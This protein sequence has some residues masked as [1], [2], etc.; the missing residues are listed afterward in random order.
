MGSA[1]SAFSGKKARKGIGAVSVA[2][3]NWRPIPDSFSTLEEVQNALRA[4]GLESSNLILGIDFTKV[5]AP[6]PWRA[7]SLPS[8]PRCPSQ[9]AR[10]PDRPKPGGRPPCPIQLRRESAVGPS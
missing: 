10:L 6:W 4:R 5:I 1:Y 3:K 8:R 7:L 2:Q 9:V